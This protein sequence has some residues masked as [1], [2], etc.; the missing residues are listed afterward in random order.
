MQTLKIFKVVPLSLSE[1]VPV[2]H[3]GAVNIIFQLFVTIGI[4]SANLVN[5][6]T[7]GIHS[8][9][10]R[11]SLGLASIPACFLFIGSLVISETPAS[12]I[13]RN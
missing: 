13:E 3:G 4:L 11:L 5:Y 7:S 8:W 9:G 10:W 1:I 2:Q 12:L 6:F